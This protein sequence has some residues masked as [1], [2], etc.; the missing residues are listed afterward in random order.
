MN[1]PHKN[2][3]KYT[4]NSGCQ[5]GRGGWGEKRIKGVNCMVMGENETCGGRHTVGY[6]GVQI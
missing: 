1:K 4:E 2:K 3:H 5:R 6:M